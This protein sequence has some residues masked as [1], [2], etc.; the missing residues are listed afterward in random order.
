MEGLRRGWIGGGRERE[1]GVG[2][3]L[4]GL[5]LMI[6]FGVVCSLRGARTTNAVVKEFW[7]A[8]RGSGFGYVS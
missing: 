5:G 8:C 7:I 4:K 3:D 6:C 2:W 1:G